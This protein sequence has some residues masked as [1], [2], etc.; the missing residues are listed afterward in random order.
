MAENIKLIATDMDGTLFNDKKELP[1]L[2]KETVDKLTEKGIA[3]IAASGRSYP[4]QEQDFNDCLDN[5][6]FICDNGAIIKHKK[7]T[8]Y[9]N[10]MS[11]SNL[12]GIIEASK[13]IDNI[14]LIFCGLKGIWHKPMEDEFKKHIKSYYSDYHLINDYDEIDDEILK[15]SVCDLDNALNNSYKV[16]ND[17]FKDEFSMAVSGEVWMDIMNK[18]VDKGLAVRFLQ[19]KLNVSKSET[20]VF[21]DFYND[22]EMLKCAEY[23]FV[24]ENANDD[25]K[26]YGKYIAPSNND[27]GVMKMIDKYI[28]K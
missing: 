8:L 22:V 6:Y 2:F 16:L 10:T 15:I 19:E 1:P 4:K 27:N 7:E 24:M 5:M 13:N 28:L 25:M 3:F 18:G 20:M 26:K 9:T 12:Q 21:G 11:M 23:S 14:F 17:L